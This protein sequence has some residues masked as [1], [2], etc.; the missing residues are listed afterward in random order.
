MEETMRVT[1]LKA[2][3]GL[4]SW[5]Y[6]NPRPSAVWLRLPALLILFGRKTVEV[7][8]ALDAVLEAAKG[9]QFRAARRWAY[10]RPEWDEAEEREQEELIKKYAD[11]RARQERGFSA[12]RGHRCGKK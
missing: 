10:A 2:L 8:L 1:I 7:A 4:A 12:L 3:C 6:E 5:G 11:R 9:P